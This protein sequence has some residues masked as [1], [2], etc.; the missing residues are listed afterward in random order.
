VK[1]CFPV[2][3]EVVEKTRFSACGVP[4]V[5]QLLD[6]SGRRQIIISGMEAHI[7]VLQTTLDLLQQN[8]QVFVVADAIC[9]R[10]EQHYENAL[11]RM[12]AAGAVISNT[13]SVLFEWLRDAKHKCFR[14]LSALIQ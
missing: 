6:M 7:C 10:Q 4:E 8:H 12:A 1:A 5:D 13:E 11:A 14:E 9:S 2:V 3:S